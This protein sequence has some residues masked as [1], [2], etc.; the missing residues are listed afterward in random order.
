MQHDIHDIVVNQ[1]TRTLEALRG[2]LLKAQEHAKERKFDENSFLQ[3]RIAPDMFPLVRQVQIA[4]DGAK[5]ACAKLSGKPAPAFA[6]EEKTLEELFQRI[7]KTLEFIQGFKK[8]DFKA[9]EAQKITFPWYPGK[10]IMGNDYIISH[11]IPNFF[12]HVSAVYMLIRGAGVN[13]GKAD[14]L[15]KQNWISA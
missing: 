2:I 12:F 7:N 3:L 11:S 15:G 9:Y 13:I 14:F 8:E 6:D 1:Y 5:F 4:C 10:A